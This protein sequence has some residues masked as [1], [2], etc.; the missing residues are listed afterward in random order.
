MKKLSF[1]IL[2][3][4]LFCAR[5]AIAEYDFSKEAELTNET[6]EY[7]IDPNCWLESTYP[8]FV[9]PNNQGEITIEEENEELKV[10]GQE[11][12]DALDH[13]IKRLEE[14]DCEE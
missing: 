11:F 3:M 14:L 12:I 13:F 10:I 8:I 7:K 4:A 2:I 5:L 6:L 1:A 9:D